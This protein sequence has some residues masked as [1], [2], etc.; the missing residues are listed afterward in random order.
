MRALLD[1][2]LLQNS[3]SISSSRSNNNNNGNK[4]ETT[5]SQLVGLPGFPFA[6]SCF[7]AFLMDDKLIS[8][9]MWLVYQPGFFP[10]LTRAHTLNILAPLKIVFELLTGVILFSSCFR[11]TKGNPKS[12]LFAVSLRKLSK[13]VYG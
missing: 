8:F 4:T 13:L 3:S 11:T 2:S 6:L 9:C 12:V 1:S 7:L 5:G 10:A